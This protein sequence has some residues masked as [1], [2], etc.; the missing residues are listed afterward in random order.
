MLQGVYHQPYA[1]DDLYSTQPTERM[2]RDPMEGDTVLI[3]A[4]TWPIESG[5][6]VWITWTK[7]GVAQPVIGAS[8][9]YNDGNN[10]Y[11]Q[12]SLGRFTRGD[13]IEYLVHA[14]EDSANE[15]VIGPFS[16][17]VISW[18]TVTGV[19]GYTDNGSS[20]DVHVGDSAGSFSPVIR[21][22]FPTDDGF[23]LQLAP[24]GAGLTI[25]GPSHYTVTDSPD[26][27]MI[28]TAALVLKIQKSPY[29]LAVYQGDGTTLIARQYDPAVFR[30]FGWASDGQSI[31]SRIEDHYLTPNGERF[32]G[33]GERYDYLDQR[34]RDVNIYVYNEYRDQAATHRTYLP[35]PLFINSAG[36]GIYIASTAYA[37][38]NIG[39]DHADMVGFTVNVFGGLG[40]TLEYY[41]FA[42]MPR[43]IL[44]RYTS[45]TGRPQLPPKWA[46]GLWLSA[47][48]W[49]TQALVKATLD[50]A[51]KYQIPA[52]ALVLE[53]WSDE[54]T[55]YIWKGSQ[56]TAKPG[57]EA[58]RY[59]DF[60]FLPDG[61]WQDPRA[62]VA[63][64][65]NRG[66]HVV[67]W[68]IP[69][70]KEIFTSNPATA[71]QQHLNDKSYAAA[72]GYVVG[73]GND[74]PYR[75]PTG[76]WF[77]DSMVPDFTNSDATAWWMSKRAYLLDEVEVDGFKN[78]GSEAV[79]G[80]NDTFADGR[81]GNVMHNAYPFCYISA[82][83][84]FVR[85]KRAAGSLFS[86]A[87]CAGS[88]TA[89]IY[90]SGDQ[91]STFDSFQQAIRAGLSI[92]ISGIPFWSWDLAGFTGDFPSAELYLRAAAMATFCPVME[93]HSEDS[94]TS[95]SRART[96]WNVQMH[97]GDQRV[98]PTFRMFANVRMNLLPYIF[99]EARRS[100]TTGV[101]LMR[102]MALA[103]PDDP[104]T[105]LLD[106]QYLFGEQL[107]VAPVVFPGATT[108]DVYVP[109]G[110]W[111]DFWN[112]GQF[113]GP[114]EKTYGV[115]LESI[116]VYA[117]PG[118][119]IP[120][121]LNA[122]YQLGG[123]IGNSIT[124]HVNLTFRIYPAGNS[125]YDYYGDANDTVRTIQATADWQAHE[126]TVELPALPTAATLQV[127]AGAPAA[128][129]VDG[130]ALADCRMLAEL[131]A[132]GAGWYWD[133]VLQA[134]L[135]KL[136]SGGARKVVLSGVDKAAYQAEFADGAGTGT[137]ANHS[138]YTGVGFVDHFDQAGDSVS[139][140]VNADAAGDYRLRFR[141]ANAAGSDA[142]RTINLDGRQLGTLRLPPLVDWDRWGNADIVAALSRGKHTITMT[143][144]PGDSTAINL[145]SLTLI[146][147]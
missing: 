120:L 18:S 49:N 13:R 92:G 4:T 99:S 123:A 32:Y 69:V 60:T 20:V 61:P 22:A 16:F 25:A 58:L 8:W 137:D 111:Y 135:V 27:L 97:T 147:T 121:N 88:Q 43:T 128:V 140:T 139:F 94:Q 66:V 114:G 59:S 133:P 29:R 6:T 122:D 138:N 15:Q 11:W 14:N 90:W 106:Q 146:R 3:N 80:R 118:A 17:L 9:Q 145:D 63:D 37:V 91:T 57:N 127:I 132:T 50:D 73:S 112:S 36:Y 141:Y 103:F 86:R 83:N 126:V 42:G 78:D 144:G 68:Q 52:T 23:H 26:T 110:E 100:A 77:G 143:Y 62:M 7:N 89:S 5:Q 38:F 35:V 33:F 125:S 93:F 115:L 2:P 67:L 116:P 87:G 102:A 40:T 34:G 119:I 109:A 53:Q 98:I 105:A 130:V 46:F 142:T 28:A 117:R 79:F 1:Y 39:T 31:I 81:R 96:P 45:I 107:L 134:T 108:K 48:E 131:Q 113:S 136:S 54:A 21:F 56:Y 47:N 72:Q 44:D 19:T 82:Y 101:P 12:A 75:I 124:S 70:F 104:A 10:S 55:F 71:P 95:D 129:T 84:R 30:N 65:H 76:Q 85:S 74:G 41:F 51:D 24:S 64:A